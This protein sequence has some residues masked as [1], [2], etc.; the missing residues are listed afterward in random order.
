M[1]CKYYDSD[2]LLKLSKKKIT[3]NLSHILIQKDQYVIHIIR[4][5][6]LDNTEEAICNICMF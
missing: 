3:V 2:Y 4:H 6:F 5:R 1:N